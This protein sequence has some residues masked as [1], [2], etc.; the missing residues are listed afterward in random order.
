MNESPQHPALA[1]TQEI[2]TILHTTANVLDELS[3]ELPENQDAAIRLIETA[4]QR[5]FDACMEAIDA[6]SN[7]AKAVTE[8]ESGP[9]SAAVGSMLKRVSDMERG[10]LARARVLAIIR[11]HLARVNDKI[12]EMESKTPLDSSDDKTRDDR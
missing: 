8:P 7:P 1:A 12:R 4:L 10:Y 9:A 3:R 6:L 5:T 11:T 2:V